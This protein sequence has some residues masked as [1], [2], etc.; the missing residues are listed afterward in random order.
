MTG[1]GL[2]FEQV[3][4]AIERA[5]SYRIQTVVAVHTVGPIPEHRR[6]I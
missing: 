1:V 6:L 2:E 4:G 3:R 5:L